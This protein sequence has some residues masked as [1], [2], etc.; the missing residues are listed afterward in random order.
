[1]YL[2]EP[3]WRRLRGGR[4]RLGH[5]AAQLRWASV[6]FQQ[7]DGAIGIVTLQFFVFRCSE[8]ARP[9]NAGLV[10][11]GFVVDPLVLEDMLRRVSN[12]D[13]QLTGNFRELLV[14]IDPALG[15]GVIDD[16]PGFVPSHCQREV[17]SVEYVEAIP[18][19]E[20]HDT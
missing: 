13:Q 9:D 4:R 2:F 18:E 10:D 12:E 16:V 8:I 17:G 15:I 7:P 3:K 6:W 5:V 20:M 19:D 1:M 11:R 14:D